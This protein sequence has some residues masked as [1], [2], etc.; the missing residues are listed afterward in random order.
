MPSEH[1]LHPGTKSK[2]L[3]MSAAAEART[4]LGLVCVMEKAFAKC[5]KSRE[6]ESVSSWRVSLH[7][8]GGVRVGSCNREWRKR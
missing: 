8:R 4:R 5:R 6:E 3:G 2:G 1:A 7:D